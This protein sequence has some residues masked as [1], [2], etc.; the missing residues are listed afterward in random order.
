MALRPNCGAAT[1]TALCGFRPG[2]RAILLEPRGA[3]DLVTIEN[4]T[5]EIWQ[6]TVQ[7]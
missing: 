4:R 2:M 7:K 5:L 1:Q 6:D 3:Y